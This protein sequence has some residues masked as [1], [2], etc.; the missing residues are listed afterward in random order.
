[1]PKK[2]RSRIFWR[3]G[4]AYGDFRDYG[5]VGGG[6]Q[7][8][9]VDGEEHATADPDVAAKLCAARLAELDAARRGR[10]LHG[11]HATTTLA[12][13]V[14]SHLRLKAASGKF[15][16]A[17]LETTETYLLRALSFL[18]AERDPASVRVQDIQSYIQWLRMHKT[19]RRVPG[20]PDPAA[21][22]T[23]SETS[24]HHHIAALSGVFARGIEQGFLV[25]G[26]NPVSALMEKPT[27]QP[28]PTGWLESHE[29]ALLL[30]AARVLAEAQQQ[31]VPETGRPGDRSAISAYPLLAT[32]LLT[33]GRSAEI[34]GLELD[35]VSFERRTIEFRPNRWRRLKTKKSG[36]KVP[37]WPQLEDILRSYLKSPNRPTGSLLFPSWAVPTEAMLTDWRKAL[38]RIAIRAG[39]R[40]GDI[41]SRQFRHTYASARLQTVD[42]GEPVAIYTVS[43]ELGHGSTAMVE[44]VYSHLGQV[45]HRSEVVEFRIEQHEATLGERLTGLR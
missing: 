18:G 5:D 23:L 20:H 14:A 15:A 35:D 26:A 1:M 24:V 43:R 27:P 38:D 16:E 36:R 8:L 6:R 34:L 45:R 10:G 13:L 42:R 33:G 25:L 31:S 44:Q 39:W 28:V 3:G 11:N 2:R 17:T 4:R 40:A 41:R 7:R 9:T 32:F 21:R 37:L 30:E 12:A 22:R 19:K 29:A